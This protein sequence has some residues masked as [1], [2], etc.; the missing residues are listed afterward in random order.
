MEEL[1]K[2]SHQSPTSHG[3]YVLDNQMWA[4]IQVNKFPYLSETE[5]ATV[6]RRL[7]EFKHAELGF[8]D[9]SSDKSS[10]LHDVQ[11]QPRQ[12]PEQNSDLHDVPT[13]AIPTRGSKRP[14]PDFNGGEP[15]TKKLRSETIYR[16]PRKPDASFENHDA[17][18]VRHPDRT[19][20]PGVVVT[21][22]AP[23]QSR[24]CRSCSK[25]LDVQSFRQHASSGKFD[26]E[27]RLCHFKA[28][29]DNKS[30]IDS[31]DQDV[32]ASPSMANLMSGANVLKVTGTPK[33]QRIITLK[34]SRQ[35]LGDL[36]KFGLR[37]PPHEISQRES[38]AGPN[39]PDAQLN[40]HI[41]RDNAKLKDEVK[42]LTEA[43]SAAE[44]SNE[45]L[46][47][48]VSTLTA[49]V[50]NNTDTFS[51]AEASKT[52]LEG[53]ISALEDEVKKLMEEK[54][55]TE[56]SNT[57]LQGRVS[58][59]TTTNKNHTDTIE[60]MEKEIKQQCRDN[61]SM[62]CPSTF[63]ALTYSFAE[64][65]GR[66]LEA[67]QKSR[68]LATENEALKLEVAKLQSQLDKI[69]QITMS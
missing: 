51:A 61:T 24:F 16:N 17:C 55:A 67:E 34:I 54:S 69:S 3:F 49:T 47:G 2:V 60:R 37:R 11:S 66:R 46:L 35:R 1:L 48:H 12:E 26:D 4:G 68:S 5:R 28:N 8:L 56:D 19:R 29:F 59:L 57:A 18:T 36:V 64:H 41:R 65:Q 62:C 7:N 38:K 45:Q 20:N 58:A 44:T 40:E 33:P 50:E 15:L 53:R 13:G 39:S 22:Q 6:R 31:K 27:C 9:D 32:E 52:A 23:S 30:S 10:K 42:K 14:S 25:L 63:L 21:A 43:K